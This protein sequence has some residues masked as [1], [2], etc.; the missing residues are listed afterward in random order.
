[1]N[2]LI[3]YTTED[4]RSQIKLRQGPNQAVLKALETKIKRRSKK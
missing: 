1:M 4:G 3:I 2:D